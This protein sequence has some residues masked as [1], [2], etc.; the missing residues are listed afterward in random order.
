MENKKVI[1]E[2][3]AAVAAGITSAL[4]GFD[5]L[6]HALVV[7]VILDYLSGVTAACITRTLSSKVGFRGILRKLSIFIVVA[8]AST[9][10]D[11]FKAG[12]SVRGAILGFFIANEGISVLENA[13]ESGLPIPKKL[14]IL[15]ESLRDAAPP[16]PPA[17]PAP[18][19]VPAQ[20]AD[21]SDGTARAPDVTAPP[22]D[23]A[24][25]EEA[26]APVSPAPGETGTKKEEP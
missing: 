7:C 2:I 23:A 26:A 13:A 8:L 19:T 4:G 3:F 1:A 11:V 22:T 10:D 20:P 25:G 12:G 9:A 15:L 14:L 16:T 17:I 6:L 24:T 5:A 18:P 21:A